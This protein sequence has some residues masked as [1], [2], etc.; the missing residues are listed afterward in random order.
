MLDREHEYQKMAECERDHW[1]YR[2]L[3]EQCLQAIAGMQAEQPLNILDAA[4]GTG[5]L[6]SKLRQSGHHRLFGFDLSATAVRYARAQGLNVEQ[7][8]L[9]DVAGC[10][11]PTRFDVIISN[12]SL[13]FLS[14][15]EQAR[16][17]HDCHERMADGG[18]LILNL[19]AR[20]AFAGMHDVA[21]G[22]GRRFEVADLHR[23]I[24]SAPWEEVTLRSWP[25]L[26]APLILVERWRQR[27]QRMSDP[28]RMAVSDVELPPQWINT[29]LHGM[30][31]IE[32]Y[33]QGPSFGSSFFLV[34]ERS[35]K[36]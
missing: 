14:E 36:D 17:L 6:L 31:R 1:W 9:R 27:R 35:V 15:K 30:T 23:L 28:E 18:R 24:G 5:G 34:L 11:S 12:D 20:A 25:M 32:R 10:F 4:C 29:S 19:P 7:A 13:Y 3:H 8:D 26:L 22:I 16:F 33:W 21:V 2:S